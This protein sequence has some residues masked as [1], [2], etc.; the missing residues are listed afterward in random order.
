MAGL[1]SMAFMEGF[2]WNMF[3]N[4]GLSSIICFMVSGSFM[5]SSIIPW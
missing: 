4:M 5:M 1:S 2:W 3:L